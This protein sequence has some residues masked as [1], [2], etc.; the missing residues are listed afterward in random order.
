[1]KPVFILPV[2]T[3][4]LLTG[5]V[6]AQTP[7]ANSQ[8]FAMDTV[9]SLEVYGDGAQAALDNAIS[10]IYHL[11]D[12]WD[13]TEEDSEVS[14]INQ[15]QGQP[16]PISPETSAL[17]EQSQELSQLTDGALDLTAYS[18]VSAWGFTTGDYRVP[19]QI[20]LD[21]LKTKIDYT[22]LSLN[23]EEQTASLPDG[24]S[25]DFGSVAKGDLGAILSEQ[26][27]NQGITSALLY[28]GGNVQTIGSKPDGT[29]WRVGIQD[30][31]NPEQAALGVVEVSQKAVVTSGS[32]QR[33]FEENGETYWHILDPETA[34]P[35][36]SGLTSVTV[37]GENGTICDGLSTALFVMGLE[38]G[39][40]FW[41]Q[42]PEL[43]LD[44]IWVEESGN[45]T[46]TSELES[47]FQLTEAQSGRE[48]TVIAP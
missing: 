35:A 34:A 30:P 44:I 36:R 26:L 16:V 42:H 14:A 43:D 23:V 46:I 2:L 24:M 40:S 47:T 32:Y 11:E 33:Y 20:E 5:C 10:T 27:Q 38:D 1:M 13:V 41:K 19:S 4:G 17:L 18:A 45:V 6:T 22:Q 15:S 3:M 8:I 9:M 31:S 48:V 28:L 21:T 29:L 39:I 7:S 25:L 37:I 12:L